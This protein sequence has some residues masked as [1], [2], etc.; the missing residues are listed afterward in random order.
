MKKDKYYP[1]LNEKASKHLVKSI[2]KD[3]IAFWFEGGDFLKRKYIF[4]HDDISES[5]KKIY[6]SLVKLNKLKKKF[7]NFFWG[8]KYYVP[9]NNQIREFKKNK[10]YKHDWKKTAHLLEPICSDYKN[11]KKLNVSSDLFLGAEK[12]S[13]IPYGKQIE[14]IIL[15]ANLLKDLREIKFKIGFL[16][17]GLPYGWLKFNKSQDQYIQKKLGKQGWFSQKIDIKN[18]LLHSPSDFD[19]DDKYIS[20]LS[21]YTKDDYKYITKKFETLDKNYAKEVKGKDHGTNLK[22]LI[23]LRK[24]INP[25]VKFKFYKLDKIEEKILKKYK[26]I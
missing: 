12:E 9:T 18:R 13:K 19:L 25:K 5:L 15:A 6:S 17:R 3:G 4:K 20:Y 1:A 16:N 14:S 11:N 26:I 8:I 10:K 24:K 21:K 23:Y 7:K 22:E 2:F